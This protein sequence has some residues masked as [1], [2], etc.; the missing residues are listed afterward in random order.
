M[1]AGRVVVINGPSSS[2]KT[3]IATATRDLVG[4][5][6]VSLSIDQLFGCV[7]A[8]RANDWSLFAALTRALFDSA[9][10]FARSGFHVIV[11][12][13]FEREACIDSCLE[14]LA[15]T[16]LLF[17]GLTCPIDVLEERERARGDRTQ[18]LARNQS[19]RVHDHAIY[20]LS[21]DSSQC[22]ARDC[23]ERIRDLLLS[24]PCRAVIEL[25]RSRGAPRSSR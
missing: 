18:G 19:S 6:S 25:A 1:H 8:E 12:A 20:D 10:S 23:A 9:A 3:A 11:D 14:S 4:P 17:V 7:H 2:G 13:V 21:I 16:D 24:S 22:E 5:Q 15:S